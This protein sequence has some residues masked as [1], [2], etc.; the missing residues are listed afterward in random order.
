M[1]TVE[2]AAEL[3]RDNYDDIFRFCLARLGDEWEAADT[4]QEVFLLLRQRIDGLDDGNLRSWLFA[5]AEN[6][7]KEARLDASRRKR[8]LILDD[9]AEAL[10][11]EPCEPLPACELGGGERELLHMLCGGMSHAEMSRALGISDGALR[12]RICRLKAK[13]MRNFC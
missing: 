4:A 11:C 1:I 12:V 6:K 13:L 2:R 3:A 9:I 10:P 5:V 8:E 7:I